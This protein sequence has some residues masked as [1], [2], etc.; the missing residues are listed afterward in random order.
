VQDLTDRV[1]V[2]TGGASGIGRGLGEALAG[3]G[4]RV[5]LADVDEAELGETVDALEATGAK[6][7]GV[8]CDVRSPDDVEGLAKDT[9]DTFGAVHVVC[10]NAGVAPTGSLLDTSL[11]SWRWVIEV[12]LLGVVHGVRSFIPSLVGQGGGHVVITASSAG[13]LSAPYLGAYTATKHAVVGLAGVLRDELVLAGVGVSVLCPG[14]VRTRIFESERVRP[15]EH[16]GSTHADPSVA[17]SFRHATSTSVLT[18]SDIGAAALSAVRENRFFVIPSPELNP[19]IEARLEEV[20][21]ALP[22][23]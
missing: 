17:E 13:L 1:A 2:V 11:D 10:L 9:L 12:N 3:A 19:F 23:E 22:A 5:V 7:L 18:P 4:A 16:P 8:R 6:V 14:L 20:R 15:L 21:A